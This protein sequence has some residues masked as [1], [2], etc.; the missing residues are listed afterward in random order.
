M[1][2]KYKIY[3]IYKIINLISHRCEYNI[4]YRRIQP[5]V[6]YTKILHTYNRHKFIYKNTNLY[7][8]GRDFIEQLIINTRFL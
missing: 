7:P 8:I 3:M 4:L 5:I 6:W 1:K 2:Y